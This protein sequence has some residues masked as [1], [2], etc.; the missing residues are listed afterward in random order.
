MWLQ[1]TQKRKVS[2]IKHSTSLYFDSIIHL[3]Y[4]TN[5]NSLIIIV[6]ISEVFHNIEI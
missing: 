1:N 4:R 5:V 2:L 3:L 6:L